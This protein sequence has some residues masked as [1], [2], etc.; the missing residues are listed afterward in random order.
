MRG[1]TMYAAFDSNACDSRV[2]QQ[3]HP[4]QPSTSPYQQRQSPRWVIIL[5]LIPRFHG[6]LLHLSAR[7]ERSMKV[8][9]DG[10]PNEIRISQTR[11]VAWLVTAPILWL[12]ESIVIV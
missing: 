3:E 11:S 10:L 8:R 7:F 12:G 4:S 5:S 6:S 2:D 9:H 1:R